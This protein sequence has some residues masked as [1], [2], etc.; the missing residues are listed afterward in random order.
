MEKGHSCYPQKM[1]FVN[2]CNHRLRKNNQGTLAEFVAIYM[3]FF[4]REKTVGI[5]K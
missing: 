2:S 3:T 4:W 1:V 5:K